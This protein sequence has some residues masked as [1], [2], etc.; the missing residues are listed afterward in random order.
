MRKEPA[1]LILLDG[2]DPVYVNKRAVLVDQMVGQVS[3]RREVYAWYDIGKTG[4]V[5][6][7][8]VVCHSCLVFAAWHI[9][10]LDMLRVQLLQWATR[11]KRLLDSK[12]MA[13]TP[14]V[15]FS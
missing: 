11:F 5:Y 9:C 4:Q 13:Q 3:G 2:D 8:C 14:A 15:W 10:C 6:R 1:A 7:R 12:G